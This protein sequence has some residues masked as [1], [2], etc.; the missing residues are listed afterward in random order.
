MKK[1]GTPEGRKAGMPEG[2][3]GDC[4]GV[5]GRPEG[6]SPLLPPES[7]E[8]IKARL[9]ASKRRIIGGMR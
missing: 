9:K 4:T 5:V 3:N 2:K 8:S 6:L 7:R 1:A